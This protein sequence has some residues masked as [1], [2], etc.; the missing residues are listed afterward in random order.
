MVFPMLQALVTVATPALSS[1]T[2]VLAPPG[3]IVKP[4]AKQYKRPGQRVTRAKTTFSGIINAAVDFK[5]SDSFRAPQI[6]KAAKAG[7]HAGSVTLEG[8]Q[9]DDPFAFE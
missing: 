1:T 9:A 7:L 8:E 4:G 6:G 3:K 2:V 5:Y